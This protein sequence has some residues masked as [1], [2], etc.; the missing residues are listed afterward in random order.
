MIPRIGMPRRPPYR[1]AWIALIAALAVPAGARG[2]EQNLYEWMATAPVVIAGHAKE[3]SGRY[4]ETEATTVL[5]GEMKTGERI[6]VDLK[7]A[8]NDREE[9][10]HA[11]RLEP[12][13]DFL[14]ILRPAPAKKRGER[15]VYQIVRGVQGAR[16][17][18]PEG[19]GVLVDAARRLIEIQDKK[20]ELLAWNEFRAMIEDANPILAETA[21]ELFIKFQRG[22]PEL[23]PSLRPMLD[24][25]RPNLRS[26]AAT[27]IGDTLR[28]MR[29]REIPD[30]PGLLSDLSGRAR[31]DSSVDVRVAATEALAELPGEAAEE[32]LREIARSD[33][34]QAVRYEA[35]KHLFERR[36]AERPADAGAKAPTERAEPGA[37][38]PRR[39]SAR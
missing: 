24:H 26:R 2:A 19:G 7:S 25:P 37:R 29:G 16:A 10:Q 28:R 30:E 9:G 39:Q 23:L 27:L 38:G 18:P 3:V 1:L 31:R 15:A 20:N 4:V 5:R 36:T 32:I 33:P 8:N 17:I 34:D 12:G 14:L 13:S 21:I 6:R 35:G 22:E 11:L